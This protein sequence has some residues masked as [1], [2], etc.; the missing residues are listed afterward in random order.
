M[1]RTISRIIIRII[2]RMNIRIII[3]IILIIVIISIIV[4]IIIRILI[5]TPRKYVF[6]SKIRCFTF[7]GLENTIFRF[8]RPR[9]YVLCV[10]NTIFQLFRP[11]KYDCSTFSASKIRFLRR[12]M[13]RQV[14]I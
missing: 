10:E 1:I 13:L 4:R 3:L 8:F 7:F 5:K 11:R 6:A 9:K 12:N 2:I 14:H